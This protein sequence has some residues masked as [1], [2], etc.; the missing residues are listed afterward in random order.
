MNN[1][2]FFETEVMRI[3]MSSIKL[4]HL[5]FRCTA[6]NDFE[7]VYFSAPVFLRVKLL[8]L[9]VSRKCL[10][11]APW[12]LNLLSGCLQLRVMIPES[13][14]GALH[15]AFCSTGCLLL[16]L[17]LLLLLFALSFSFSHSFSLK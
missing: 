7:L 9:F 17:S 15:Q 2:P 10:P 12:W 11:G 6:S 8:K 14:D 4:T 16:P 13:L 3:F 1:D 5:D